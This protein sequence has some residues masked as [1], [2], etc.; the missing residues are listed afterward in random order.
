ME[1]YDAIVIGTGQAG[2]PL[3]GALGKAGRRTAI[4]EKGRVGGTCVIDGCTP[5][6]TMVASARVAHLARRAADYGV[7]TGGVEVDLS[8]VR[9]RKR[10]VVDAWSSGG[11]KGLGRI[12]AIELVFGTARFTGPRVIEVELVDGGMRSMT[13]DQVFINTGTRNRVPDIEG[14][15]SVPWLD[16]ASLME[17]AEVP[18]HLVVLG[19]GFIGLE[20]AQMFRRFGARVTVIEAADRI[21]PREDD[22]VREA[23]RQILEEDGIEFQCGTL[24]SEV[25]QAGGGVEVRLGDSGWDEAVSGSHLMVSVGRVPNA[26]DLGL[27]L[28]GIERT[29]RG[30]IQ[31]DDALRTTADGVWALGDVNGG[32]PFTHIAYDDYR[33]VRENVLGD[34]GASRAGRIVPYTLF[35]D[36]QLGRVGLTEREAREGGH[37][38]LLA[39]LPM[40]RVARAVETDET[41]G[42]MKAVVDAQSGHVLG[43]SVLGIEGGEIAS[44]IQI[45]MMGGLT[46]RDLRDAAFSHPTLTESLNNLFATIE[47]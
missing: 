10:G 1:H 26:D 32:P 39:K 6:K 24:A 22:D 44:A 8:V 12:E 33:V 14:L 38:I 5:T 27:E 47:G 16:N 21:A 35:T 18:D 25:R 11:E 28:A 29:E 17:L 34:G 3:A 37:E 19:G 7:R 9:R 36:P 43:A 15:D 45:A 13:A 2:K 23:L 41:R 46:W 4:I 30:F 20:F 31:V 40:E 42:L